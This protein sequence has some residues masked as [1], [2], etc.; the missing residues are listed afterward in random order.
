MMRYRSGNDFVVPDGRARADRR[1]PARRRAVPQ[2]VGR[3]HLRALPGHPHRVPVE[4]RRRGGPAAHGDPLRRPGAVPRA[5][6]PVPPDLQQGRVPR[7]R[8]HDPVRQ[9]AACAATGP[10]CVV[11]TWG[12][13]VQRSLLAAQQ[14][15]KDGI[16]VAVLDLR[17]IVPY[18]WDAIAAHV[19]ADQPRH[20]RA[21]GSADVRLRR[22]DRRAHRRAS[23]SSTSTRRS[24]ASARS[25]ARS[26]T[27]PISRRRSCPDRP[28]CSR[29]S[30]TPPRLLTGTGFARDSAGRSGIL[31]PES[32]PILPS[33]RSSWRDAA[34]GGAPRRTSSARPA[35]SRPRS[36]ASF[37]TRP[38][39]S[40]RRPASTSSSTAARTPSTASTSSRPGRGRS[41]RSARSRG[42]SSTRRRSRSS[43]N[44]TFVVADAPR[45]QERIQIFSSTGVADRRLHAART[46]EAARHDRELGGER[47]RLAPVHRPVDPD[48]PA[49]NGRAHHRVPAVG[50]RQPDVR[51][52][53]ADRATKTIRICT[54]RS[55]PACRSSI[56]PA[57][58]TSCSR[59]ATP[60]FRKYDRAGR[61][62]F[63]RHIEGREIDDFVAAQPTAWK[64]NR[65]RRAAARQRRSSARP[66]SIRAAG[67]GCRSRC[68]SR[69][70]SI[71]TATRS[72]RS[73]SGA[74]EFWRPPVCSSLD[75]PPPRHAGSVRIQRSPL[76]CRIQC[77]RAAPRAVYCRY[78]HPGAGALRR[79]P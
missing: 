52:P 2:P 48:E 47:H 10:T 29:P 22:R 44:G 20:H 66:P 43:R 8:L 5:Q 79:P 76:S 65:D 67:S 32:R 7:R 70:S 26:P 69:T 24:G 35:P 68:R 71:G 21:R 78:R 53:A 19:Q 30:A 58:S 16:S 42:G 14:A 41:C 11:V 49:G 9:G 39:S 75:D 51:P 18:D 4:R 28:T 45:Q 17:T 3:E 62:L 15:E 74:P 63:E 40:S 50:R 12:A 34:A 72:P 13:L 55:T 6:A 77:R 27:A 54:S 56:R 25:T 60:V 1:L 64:T 38:P 46:A 31:R 36:P 57:A 23:C 73:S 61:L 33:A 37:A 59:P